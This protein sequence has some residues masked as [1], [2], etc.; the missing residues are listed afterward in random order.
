MDWKDCINTAANVFTAIG[1]V[2]SVIVSLYLAIR[3]PKKISL[4]DFYFIQKQDFTTIS[5]EV[6]NHI[7]KE[8]VI[9]D[10]SLGY[11]NNYFCSLSSSYFPGKNI[12]NPARIGSYET[13]VLGEYLFGD[14]EE[15]LISIDEFK[16]KFKRK[17]TLLSKLY[18]KI[19]IKIATNVGT[20]VFKK[21]LKIK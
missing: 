10:I 14:D 6:N 3:K 21:R 11:R 8:I 1:T 9:E 13:K 17:L 19:Q 4:L 5:L 7:D 16:T 15:H 20:F 12:L 18:P 2:G